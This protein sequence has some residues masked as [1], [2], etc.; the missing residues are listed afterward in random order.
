MSDVATDQSANSDTPS[1][2]HES[3]N[4]K[5]SQPV[6][7]AESCR[8]NISSYPEGLCASESPV[9]QRTAAAV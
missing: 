2:V 6:T 3:L 8:H 9:I 4:R 1:R 7:I 5:L